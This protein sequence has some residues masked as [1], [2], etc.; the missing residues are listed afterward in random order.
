MA[1]VLV[2]IIERNQTIAGVVMTPTE[3]LDMRRRSRAKGASVQEVVLE[4]VRD[5][6]GN[7]VVL[8]PRMKIELPPELQ[9]IHLSLAD[10]KRRLLGST[11]ET[12]RELLRHTVACYPRLA[13]IVQVLPATGGVAMSE[14][15]RTAPLFAIAL[16]LAIFENDLDREPI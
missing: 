4:L 6:N 8:E 12:N 15:W 2:A 7:T 9:V 1:N 16:G 13:N 10:A 3:V 5:Y 14:R 11:A